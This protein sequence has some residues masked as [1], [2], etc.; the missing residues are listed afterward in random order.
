MQ[1][2]T[3]GHMDII[4]LVHGNNPLTHANNLHHAT[5]HAAA[6]ASS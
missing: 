1:L 3:A 2:D 5:H 4:H 6:A